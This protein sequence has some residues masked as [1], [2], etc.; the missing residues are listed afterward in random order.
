MV[1]ALLL[2]ALALSWPL[3]A[4]ARGPSPYLPLLLEPEVERD[5]E[6]V[7]IL[8][9]SATMS[10]PIAAGT[11]LDA[12]PEACRIDAEVCARVESYLERYLPSFS[13]THAAVEV[14]WAQGSGRAVPNRRGLSLDDDWAISERVQWSPF[15]H[16]HVT[17][18]GNAHDGDVSPTGTLLS[19]GWSQ[20]Q[21]DL[22]WR[23]HWLSPFTDSSM[24]ISTEAETMPSL[25][26]SNYEPLSRLGV[27][28]AVIAA[29]MAESDLIL[30]DDGNLTSG[31]PII[32]GVQLSI[33]P[34]P[35]WSIGASRLMQ[36]GGGGRDSSFSSFL[37]AFFNPAQIDNVQ[38]G[39]TTTEQFGNQV[40]SITSRFVFPG[41]VPFAAYVEYGGEDTLNRENYLLGNASLSLGLDFPQLFERFDLTYE[42]SEW[43]NAWYV[44]PLYGDGL[45]NDGRVLGHWGADQRQ[46]G[47]GVG[48]QTH[49]IRL[50]WQPA[51]GGRFELRYRTIENES[52]STVSYSRGHDF[53]LR[54][55]HPWRE[56]SVG[57]ELNAGRDVDGDS[58]TRV[59]AF[60][61]YAPASERAETESRA[62]TT[63]GASPE[64]PAGAELFVDLGTSVSHVWI[65][66]DR[67]IP[68]TAT[69]W[70]PGL[71]VAVG[72]RRAVTKRQ[73]LGIRL[74]LDEV[75]DDWLLGVRLLDYRLRLGKHFALSAFFGAA[76]WALATP[77][78]G[79]YLGG[80][81]QWRDILPGWHLGFDARYAPNISRDDLVSEDPAGNR[82][83]SYREVVGLSFYL[84]RGF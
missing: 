47:D 77:A 1:R 51:F 72:A 84:S 67:T 39:A 6:R 61:L 17:L 22:G 79:I 58:F 32:G 57:G 55:A 26:I 60:V 7:L 59:L 25:T 28:W 80:G 33:E 18:G 65:D 12:L 38:P 40:A 35:G 11:V 66:L 56:F 73:D 52:Y 20:F 4:L 63:Q 9:G 46:K 48:A 10:R 8:A 54:Y 43:Q 24:L 62:E 14:G 74:E 31:N 34:V 81:V 45:A 70:D 21:V 82:S 78:L 27:R 75:D 68:T 16:V 41:P 83:S 44:H 71:H 5:I 29:Q 36:F 53:M 69:G 49:M 2:V 19:V 23:D 50:G 3:Q 64:R 30:D 76:R 15:D 13:L 37:E 42:V